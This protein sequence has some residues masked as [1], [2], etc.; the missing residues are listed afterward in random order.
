M[1]PSRETLDKPYLSGYNYN[2]C[3]LIPAPD[4][5]VICPVVGS[6]VTKVLKGF[7]DDIKSQ[8]KFLSNR[9]SCSALE[10]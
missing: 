6:V 9:D 4:T 1:N 8:E 10:S 2:I 3:R 5:K 7:K